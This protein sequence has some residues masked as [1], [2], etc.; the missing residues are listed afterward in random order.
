MEYENITMTRG[1]TVAFN[2]FVFGKEGE[3][4]EVDSVFFTA[5]ERVSGEEV[6]QLSLEHGIV[7]QDGLISVRIAPE[8]TKDV[9]VGIYF[10]DFQIKVNDDV[11]TLK[12]GSLTLEWDATY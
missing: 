6:F 9:P 4:L 10:Y 3:P 11:F 5:K 12:K 7:Q 2:C 1:D 8:D